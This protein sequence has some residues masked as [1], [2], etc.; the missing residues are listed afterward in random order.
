MAIEAVNANTGVFPSPP[1]VYLPSD[2]ATEAAPPPPFVTAPAAN[3]EAPAV[4]VT[5]QD[6][7]QEAPPPAAPVENDRGGNID[8]T[9]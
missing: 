1:L 3:P 7:P 2:P 5:P 9:A 4:P 8:T 6:A